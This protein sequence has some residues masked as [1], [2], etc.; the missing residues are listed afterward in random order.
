MSMGLFNLCLWAAQVSVSQAMNCCCR[1]AGRAVA[2]LCE[3]NLLLPQAANRLVCKS[4]EACI[5]PDAVPPVCCS[6]M[7]GATGAAFLVNASVCFRASFGMCGG[8]YA[9]KQ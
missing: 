1:A 6:P 3:D 7:V 2:S 9:R 4:W 5:P 8:Q